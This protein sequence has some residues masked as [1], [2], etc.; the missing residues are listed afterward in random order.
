MWYWLKIRHK[1]KWNRVENPEINPHPYSHLI[2]HRRGNNTQWRKEFLHG[3]NGVRI[4]PSYTKINSKWLKELNI[5]HDMNIH[6]KDWCWS[7]NSS[8]LVLDAKRV[9]SLE[10]TLMLGKIE[11]GRRRGWQR[12]T[13]LDGI[14]DSMD[15]SWASSGSWWQTGEPGVLQSMGSQ[16][17]RH[18]WATEQQQLHDKAPRRQYR[19]NIFWHK[20]YRSFLSQS[21]RQKKKSK[22]KQMGHNQTCKLCTAKEKWKWSHSVVSDSL[23]PHG[24]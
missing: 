13:W 4:F 19:Q 5:R 7:W 2:F 14:T 23:R 16:R 15:M 22:N 3:N 17:A 1:D 20:P 18:H 10:K 9:N 6:W 8:T 12:A 11:G 24:Q 21:P